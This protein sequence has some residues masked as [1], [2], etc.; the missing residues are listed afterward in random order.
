[1]HISLELLFKNMILFTISLDNLFLT[2]LIVSRPAAKRMRS[3]VTDVTGTASFVV[4]IFV[5]KVKVRDSY[6]M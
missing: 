4:G 1:M 5:C 2:L 6:I 3:A